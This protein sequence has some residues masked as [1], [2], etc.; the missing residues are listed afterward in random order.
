MGVGT[1]TRAIKRNYT[2]L[3]LFAVAIALRII[4]LDA[5]GLW[6]DEAYSVHLA[7]QGLSGL[8][9][10]L[11]LES[12]PPLYYLCLH[13]WINIFGSSE[14]A[15]RALSLVFSLGTMTVLYS[16]G[17]KFFSR[18]VAV[19]VAALAAFSP[20][21]I[22]YAQET[23][24][25]SLLALLAAGLLYF[26]I[27][28]AVGS[29]GQTAVAPAALRRR[30]IGMGLVGLLMLYTH[31]VA[32]WFVAACF[33]VALY[34]AR[35]QKTRTPVLLSLAGMILAYLPW[36]FVLIKQVARQETVLQWFVPLWKGKPIWGH[37]FDSLSSYLFGPFPPY[38]AIQSAG[39]FLPIL[40]I[41]FAAILGWGLISHRKSAPMRACSLI[42]VLA[43]GFPLVYSRLFQPIYIPGRTD[44]YLQP[45]FLLLVGVG[46]LSIAGR[47]IIQTC[48]ILLYGALSV[49]VLVPY[50]GNTDKNASRSYMA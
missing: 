6:L 5:K 33:I 47:R 24:M 48:V 32:L 3:I 17:R 28:A 37:V 46:I 42:A 34:Y 45:V 38:L 18:S 30:I 50:Y 35:E 16:L 11:S 27:G 12:T 26:T 49:W 1:I 9:S 22:Y 36:L 14:G 31:T 10:Q 4:T 20:L 39:G 44:Q 43:F 41:L 8:M 21:Q 25:Y 2:F 40:F 7:R 13:F 23:R 15:L 19:V 29:S